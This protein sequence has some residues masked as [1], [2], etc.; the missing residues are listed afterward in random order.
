MQGQQV[1]QG[2][3]GHMPDAPPIGFCP[4]RSPRGGHFRG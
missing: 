3:H 4:H 1:A 2:I